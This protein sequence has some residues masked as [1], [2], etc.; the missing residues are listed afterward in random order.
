MKRKHAYCC[1]G[2]EEPTVHAQAFLLCKTLILFIHVMF[3]KHFTS[4]Q[5]AKRGGQTT[6]QYS[7]S[8]VA[9]LRTT[10]DGRS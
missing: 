6:A 9:L 5:V 7:N 8:A 3:A 2:R 4:V 10:A 1:V